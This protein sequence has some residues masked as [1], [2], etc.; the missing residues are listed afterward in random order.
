[1]TAVAEALEE[2]PDFAGDED[3]DGAGA[4]GA[5]DAAADGAADGD[6]APAT[7][8]QDAPMPQ[9]SEGT[10]AVL[11]APAATGNGASTAARLPVFDKEEEEEVLPFEHDVDGWLE[12]LRDGYFRQI[13]EENEYPEPPT[14]HRA[15]RYGANPGEP[16]P[17]GMYPKQALNTQLQMLLRARPGDTFVPGKG[18]KGLPM[19]WLGKGV[20]KGNSLAGGDKGRG[21]GGRG[22]GRGKGKD[23]PGWRGGG[24]QRSIGK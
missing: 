15:T 4:E 18:G 24:V 7:S 23:G 9:H 6:A 8:G 21:K 1:M 22:R 16:V 19:P 3:D 13:R 2:P 12:L 20:G 14:F 10:V 17:A 5:E 11:A